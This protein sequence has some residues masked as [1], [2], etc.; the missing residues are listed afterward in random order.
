MKLNINNKIAFRVIKGE[1]SA[2]RKNLWICP[3]LKYIVE[4]PHANEVDICRDLFCDN[5]EARRAAVKNIL[6]FF[7]QQGLLAYDKQN[8]YEVTAIG[9]KAME[10][11]NVWQ[12]LKG[13]FLMTLWNPEGEMPYI[14]DVQPVPDSWYDKGKNEP[15]EIPEEYGRNMENLTVC[16]DKIMLVSTGKSFVTT[17]AK[18]EFKA[19]LKS[20]G[21]VKFVGTSAQDG[22]E[23][24]DVTFRIG[25]ELM[26]RLMDDDE[27]DDYGF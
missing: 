6:F 26:S 12:G 16:S 15:E 24:F 10:T 5:G 23:S 18:M 2:L 3:F 25:D 7:K 13:A 14:L 21:L 4:H 1:I 22:L 19:D 20:N 17:Y 11:G 9:M 8:G 27:D